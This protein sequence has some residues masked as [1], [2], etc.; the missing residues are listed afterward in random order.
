MYLGFDAF[1][2]PPRKLTGTRVRKLAMSY[3]PAISPV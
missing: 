2:R 3:P 1:E